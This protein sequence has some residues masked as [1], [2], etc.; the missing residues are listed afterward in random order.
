MNRAEH[1]KKLIAFLSSIKRPDI[2]LDTID[3]HE[4]LISSGLVDSLAGI[5]II[6]YLEE[7]YG[8]D[9]TG[10]GVD[11]GELNSIANILDLIERGT[12]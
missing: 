5:E 7:E 12:S 9:F 2:P 10:R 6:G 4:A 1:K 8:I 11:P 3:E